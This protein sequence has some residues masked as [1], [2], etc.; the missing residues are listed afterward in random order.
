MIKKFK[1]I[2]KL[3]RLETFTS[4]VIF[5]SILGAFMAGKDITP[6][7]LFLIFMAN[8]SSV[9]FAFM[10]NDTEDA[11][12]DA[13]DPKKIHRNPVSAGILS[14]KDAYAASFVVA[15]ISLILFALVNFSALGVGISLLVC[16][17]FYSWKQVRFKGI[18]WAD[19]LSHGYFLAAGILLSSYLS[20]KHFDIEIIPAFIGVGLFSMSGD[21]Y[22]ELRDYEVDRKS[23]LKNTV[24]ILGI[25]ITTILKNVMA[26]TSVIILF[27]LFSIAYK[28]IYLPSLLIIPI[29]IIAVIL[30]NRLKTK[31]SL[32][33]FDNRLI[34]DPLLYSFSI[35]LGISLYIN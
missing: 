26:A 22:N 25:K 14:K 35:I 5:L 2:Y 23:G 8:L 30:Y 28:R 24:S 11:D 9:S 7:K 13:M 32:L 17:F 18:A 4:F 29:V 27:V 34:Y 15:G 12:D 10:I 33:H 20:F 1:N 31:K 6:V 16:G 3:T 19:F 21:L